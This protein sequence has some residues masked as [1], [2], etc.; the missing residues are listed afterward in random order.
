[1]SQIPPSPLPPSDQPG[2]SSPYS[3]APVPP[4]PGAAPYGSTPPPGTPGAPMNY[5]PGVPAYNP[6]DNK[7]LVSGILAI[8]LGGLGIHKFYLGMTVPGIILIVVTIAGSWVFCLGPIAAQVIG[9]IEGIIY[10]TKTDEQFH[11]D[12]VVNKKQWF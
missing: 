4:P 7:K 1:M 11:Q 3:T 10:L 5:Q 9:I 2:G 12:Y 8:L 6:A